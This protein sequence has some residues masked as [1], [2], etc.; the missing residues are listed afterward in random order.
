MHRTIPIIRLYR[1][2]I[3]SIQIEVSD[4]LIADLQ[5][6]V[7]HEVQRNNVKAL[8]VEVSGIDLFDSYIARSIRDLAHIC[9][10]MGVRTVLVGLDPGMAITL[11][12]MGMVMEGVDT[13]LNMELALEAYGDLVPRRALGSEEDSIERSPEGSTAPAAVKERDD[14]AAS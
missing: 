13:A 10:M 6:D 8:I 5:D 14:A 7:A 4:D 11:V 3:V 9:R 2:L 1:T 12:E